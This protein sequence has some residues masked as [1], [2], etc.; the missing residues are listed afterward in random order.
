MNE[1]IFNGTQIGFKDIELELKVWIEIRRLCEEQLG[2]YDTSYKEDLELLE[3]DEQ[4]HNLSQNYKA[5]V[6]FRSGEKK[7]LHYL[8]DCSEKITMLFTMPLKE[9]RKE[10]NKNA[11]LYPEMMGYISN[12]VFHGLQLKE[13]KQIAW[14]LQLEDLAYLIFF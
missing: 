1:D 2:K 8:I 7:I 6:L 11:E 5:A 14:S 10:V 9:A 3:I 13:N 4:K 12:N